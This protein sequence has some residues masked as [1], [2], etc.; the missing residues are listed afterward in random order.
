MS[1]NIQ[2]DGPWVPGFFPLDLQRFSNRP[3]VILWLCHNICLKI[4]ISVA[5]IIASRVDLKTHCCLFLL[6]KS[7]LCLFKTFCP[8]GQTPGSH[9][10]PI[11]TILISKDR[12]PNEELTQT[13]NFR[14]GVAYPVPNGSSPGTQEIRK[15]KYRIRIGWLE[16]RKNKDKI[17]ICLLGIHKHKDQ[18]RMWWLENCKNKDQIRMWWLENCKN[19]DQIRIWWLENC[20]NKDQIRI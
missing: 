19:K 6:H 3:S 12:S 7:F 9:N 16:N 11:P 18:I 1:L 10:P 17:R 2:M 20:K 15:N 14:E 8:G 13:D 4:C 5:Y